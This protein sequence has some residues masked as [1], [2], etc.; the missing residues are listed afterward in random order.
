MTKE[1]VWEVLEAYDD[2][3]EG[4]NEESF[5]IESESKFHYYVYPIQFEKRVYFD[6]VVGEECYWPLW[7]KEPRYSEA[8]YLDSCD[9]FIDGEEYTLDELKEKLGDYNYWEDYD[10]TEGAK[11]V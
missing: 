9:I 3:N 5:H 7:A 10:G 4:R 8:S 2:Y 1:F 11:E 6:C